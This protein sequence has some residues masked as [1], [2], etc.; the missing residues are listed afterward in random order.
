MIVIRLM[1][2]LGNQLFQYAFGRALER[3]DKQVFFER[4]IIDACTARTYLLDDFNIKAQFTDKVIDPEILEPSLAY[5]PGVLFRDDCTLT[6]YWQCE[7]YFQDVETQLREELTPT[8]VSYRTLEIIRKFDSNSVALHIRRSDSLSARAMPFHGLLTDGDYYTKAI[9]Y[10]RSRIS[11]PHFFV[12][13]DDIPWCKA[14]LNIKA[15]FI[16]HNP[17]SGTC[18]D[19]GIVTKGNR[20]RECED[21]W[22]MS[23]CRHTIIANSSFS[24]WGAWL[25]DRIKDRIVVA[26]KK[27][28]VDSKL[29]SQNIVPFRWMTI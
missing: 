20:G 18:D 23:L 16:D 7:K 1:G 6:G 9:E 26:P 4:G 21:L 5:N 11:T 24:W 2:G 22:L 27:W 28:F 12:F 29:D 19:Q 15:T 8:K 10:I 25:G 3:L 17:M 14:N 13:S